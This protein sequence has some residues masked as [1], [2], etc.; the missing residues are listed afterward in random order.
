VAL[1]AGHGG[2]GNGLGVNRVPLVFEEWMVAMAFWALGDGCLLE[3]E[4][5]DD[6]FD[7]S[8]IQSPMST[9][10]LGMGQGS[11]LTS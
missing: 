7:R 2:G 3:E 1:G 8:D 4:W 6:R 9:V 11:S 5:L 10:V